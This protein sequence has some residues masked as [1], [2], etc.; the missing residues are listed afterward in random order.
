MAC[1]CGFNDRRFALLAPSA[2][3]VMIRAHMGGIA[4]ENLGL[5]ALRKGFDL[6]VFLLEPLLDQSRI[7]LLRTV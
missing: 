2:P 5:F 6:R 4:E 1:A 3:G 7:A